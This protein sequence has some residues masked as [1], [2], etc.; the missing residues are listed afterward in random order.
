MYEARIQTKDIHPK[1]RVIIDRRFPD[2][3]NL[4]LG[5]TGQ[6]DTRLRVV[7]TDLVPDINGNE[8]VNLDLLILEAKVINKM[9]R[10]L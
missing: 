10:K 9:Q 4:E 3:K 1:P 7:S 5:D 8:R 2:V 6:L